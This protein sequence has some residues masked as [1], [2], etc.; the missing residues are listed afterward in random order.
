MGRDDKIEIV[1]FHLA[2]RKQP[3]GDVSHGW[4][5]SVAVAQGTVTVGHLGDHATFRFRLIDILS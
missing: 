3:K 1:I 5:L 4:E 2:R